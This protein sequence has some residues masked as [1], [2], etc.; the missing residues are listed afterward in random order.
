M[1]AV[2]TLNA[3]KNGIEIS[4]PG[5]PAAAV[6]DMLKTAGYRWSSR[7][8]IW[9]SK[10]SASAFEVAEKITGGNIEAAE[11]VHNNADTALDLWDRTRWTPGPG[12]DECHAHTVGSNY[13]RG[14]SN[15]EIAATV[16][17]EL[18][19]RFPGTKWSATTG[20]YNSISL[21]LKSSPYHNEKH[22][23]NRREWAEKSPEISAIIEYAEKLLDSYNYNDSDSMTDYFDVNFYDSVGVYYDY[24]QTEPTAEQAA[25]IEDFRRRIE[26]EKQKEYEAMEKRIA[27][28][29][30]Q[31]KA[32]EEA[33]KIREEKNREI[34]SA[35]VSAATVKELSDNEQYVIP[36]CPMA[37]KS[38]CIDEAREAAEE[39]AV[40]ISD[41]IILQEITAPADILQ[42]FG[43]HC[44]LHEIPEIFQGVGGSRTFD[45]RIGSMTD[46]HNMN[47]DER[48]SV[49][50]YTL[51]VA[52]YDDLG[53]LWAVVDDEGYNYSRYIAVTPWEGSERRETVPNDEE[54]D[55]S[56]TNSADMLEDAST[57]IIERLS[58][59]PDNWDTSPE[60]AAAME[61]YMDGITVEIIRAVSI[62]PLKVW[63]YKRMSERNNVQEQLTRA[64]IPQGQ[65]VTIIK[66]NEWG[67]IS[68]TFATWDS[69]Q[70]CRYAQY[71]KAAKLIMKPYR[72]HGLYSMTVHDGP[73]ILIADGFVNVPDS[74]LWEDVP[75][76][77][78]GATIRR[79]RFMSCDPAAFRAVRDYIKGQ[80]VKLW[81]D[82][83]TRS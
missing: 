41:C 17:K 58:L 83:E 36:S 64:N 49:K 57:E 77:T 6:L 29:L 82:A 25:E 37:R 1:N 28:E 35:F 69:W 34:I 23:E 61:K 20:G 21:Y 31:R 66:E 14:M 65:R 22:Y 18:S 68:T 4:F 76:N 33:Y 51:A 52:I 19:R 63:L 56:A 2:Y 10:Q 60:Y 16:K 46:Y 74:V 24:K 81:V 44:L 11:T 80:G 38:A 40:D 53:R 27:E 32:E 67:G 30:E 79:S 9:W 48:D 72:K 59:S 71:E 26:E 45:S 7:R 5:K 73:A 39:N 54:P 78:S 62:E 75:S 43:D 42:Q 3:E 8:R 70:P 13:K 15:K 50:W 12:G 55:E 47:A